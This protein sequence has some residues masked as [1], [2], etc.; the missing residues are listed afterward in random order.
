MKSNEVV[1]IRYTKA[2][3]YGSG[4]KGEITERYVIPT[5]IPPENIKAM[6]VT[7]LNKDERVALNQLYNQYREYYTQQVATIFSFEDW[8][9]HTDNETCIDNV[10]WRTFRCD[11][12]EILD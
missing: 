11:N 12:I 8:L 4:S 6:D 2:T 1:H 7:Q 10:K 5:F 9:S 3:N